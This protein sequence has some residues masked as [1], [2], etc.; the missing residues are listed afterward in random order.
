M[1]RYKCSEEIEI[2]RDMADSARIQLGFEEKER[3]TLEKLVTTIGSLN[4]GIEIN[5]IYVLYA[6]NNPDRVRIHILDTYNTEVSQHEKY[7]ARFKLEYKIKVDSQGKRILDNED[8]KIACEVVYAIGYILTELLDNIGGKCKIKQFKGYP[9]SR[10]ASIFL[11]EFMMPKRDFEEDCDKIF[12]VEGI[13]GDRGITQLA[14]IYNVTEGDVLNRGS[15]LG[16][17]V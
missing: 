9:C 8:R 1:Y 15:E 10:R 17:F 14:N 2:I 7:G 6:R 5:P 13:V 3:V 4:G 12:K 11:K 16:L